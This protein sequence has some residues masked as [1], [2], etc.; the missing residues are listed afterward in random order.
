MVPVA[1]PRLTPR[2][3]P[4]EAARYATQ[5]DRLLAA[6]GISTGTVAAA[7]GCAHSIAWKWRYGHRLP[8]LAGRSK[9]RR[10]YLLLRA[11]AA[12]ERHDEAA[13]VELAVMDNEGHGQRWARYDRGWVWVGSP[14]GPRVVRAAGRRRAGLLLRDGV[15]Q[16]GWPVDPPGPAGP[17]DGVASGAHRRPVGVQGPGARGV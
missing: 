14:E 3:L 15:H 8:S 9:G 5:A 6:A 4:P 1:Y 10:F 13:R 11:L 2:P 17:P 16:P 7:F 12:V